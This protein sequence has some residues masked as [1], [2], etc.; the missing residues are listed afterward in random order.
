MNWQ[1]KKKISISNTGKKRTRKQ[2]QNISRGAKGKKRSLEA[3][4][5][6]RNGHRGKRNYLWKGEKAGYRAKHHWIESERGKP[7][8]CEHCKKS[9]LKHRQ[10]HWANKSRKHKRILSDW[11][12]LC[13]K[14]HKIYDRT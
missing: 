10:Y 3:R 11:I 4:E 7:H 8:F 12:R 13:V 14:C 2:I 5:N 1:Q 9:D 6:I